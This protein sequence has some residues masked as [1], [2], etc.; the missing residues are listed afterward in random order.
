MKKI[1]I[2]NE[3]IKLDQFLKWA[4]VVST[5]AEAKELISE[6]AIMVNSEIELRRGR[7][8]RIND[9]IEVDGEKFIIE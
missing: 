3:Y 4:E 5:G 1:S 7:K 6:G 9:I 2:K 8:L